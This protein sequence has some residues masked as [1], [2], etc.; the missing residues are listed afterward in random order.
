M[1]MNKQKILQHLTEVRDH[2]GRNHVIEFHKLMQFFSD[3]YPNM[4]FGQTEY[5]F[6][7]CVDEF[8]NERRI[9]HVYGPEC[10][11]TNVPGQI[12]I[13]DSEYEKQIGGVD[14]TTSEDDL[15]ISNDAWEPLPL[16]VEE[17]EKVAE[18]GEE[19]ATTLEQDNGYMAEHGSIAVLTVDEIR[20]T[21]EA[22]RKNKGAIF[23]GKLVYIKN[24]LKPVLAIFDKDTRVGK[25]VMHFLKVLSLFKLLS[26]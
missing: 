15:S 24:L 10:M 8:I 9:D 19:V 23:K 3:L 22:L 13:T 7:K 12:R 25:K 17:F 4:P 21:S 6:N 11:D 1:A 16:Q 5:F 20:N 14:E 26:S 2:Y 18:A